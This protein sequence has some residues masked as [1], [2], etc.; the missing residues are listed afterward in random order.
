MAAPCVPPAIGT[1]Q[2]QSNVVSEMPHPVHAMKG[3]EPES[4]NGSD[5][6]ETENF[7]VSPSRK[8]RTRSPAEIHVY[9]H[10]QRTEFS[11]CKLPL[12]MLNATTTAWLV[13]GTAA[14]A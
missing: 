12:S 10:S 6:S 9:C 8:R 2:T 5:R 14:V 13:A 3:G 11:S 7:N 4:P 1:Y